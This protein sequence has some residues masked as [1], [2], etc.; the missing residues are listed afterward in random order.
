ME[1]LEE[2]VFFCA[3]LEGEKN[4]RRKIL[5]KKKEKKNKGGRKGKC[6]CRLWIGNHAVLSMMMMMM[7]MMKAVVE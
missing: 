1:K 3:L 5:K 6:V 2:P 7:M 4:V